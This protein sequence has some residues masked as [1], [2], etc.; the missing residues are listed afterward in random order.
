MQYMLIWCASS[1]LCDFIGKYKREDIRKTPPTP[2]APLCNFQIFLPFL[3]IIQPYKGW[4]I[5]LTES[6][7]FSNE[8]LCVQIFDF[9]TGWQIFIPKWLTLSCLQINTLSIF[10]FSK[11]SKKL[12]FPQWP[13]NSPVTDSGKATSSNPS[14]NT[15]GA[16]VPSLRSS[17]KSW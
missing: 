5:P 7:L 10:F 4:T 1:N 11:W 6:S 17:S 8:N 16:M 13:K 9:L 2:N 12:W 15:A 3:Q 14:I